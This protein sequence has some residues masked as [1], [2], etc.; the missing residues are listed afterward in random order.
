MRLLLD[1]HVLLWWADGSAQLGARA[2]SLLSA[3]NAEVFVSAASWWE[4]SIK[5]AHGRLAVDLS[6]LESELR[7]R[8]VKRLDMSFAHA[9][10]AAGL[11]PHHGDPFD[12]MLVAQ[13]D[14]E[15][16]SLLTRDKRLKTYGSMVLC[17]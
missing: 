7:A 8:S 16:L 3:G 5:K 4:I 1:S 6:V 9:R 11:P 13:A 10:A 12:R 15:G 2:K 14:V 17:T